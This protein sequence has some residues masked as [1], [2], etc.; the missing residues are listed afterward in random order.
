M[1]RIQGL[2][3]A[4]TAIDHSKG[5]IY[6]VKELSLNGQSLALTVGPNHLNLMKGRFIQLISIYHR[7]LRP[8]VHLLLL[9]REYGLWLIWRAKMVKLQRHLHLR[10]P[11]TNQLQRRRLQGLPIPTTDL[12]YTEDYILRRIPQM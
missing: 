5:L 4:K 3:R 12:N 7:V 9:N 1:V 6:W 8:V 11:F 10:P 2:A